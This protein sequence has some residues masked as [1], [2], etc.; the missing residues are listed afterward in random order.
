MRLSIYIVGL[1]AGLWLQQLTLKSSRLNRDG[2]TCQYRIHIPGQLLA[3][4]G[5]VMHGYSGNNNEC[6]NDYR[7][8]QLADVGGFVVA[9]P[10]GTRDQWNDRFSDVDYSFH[11]GI[12]TLWIDFIE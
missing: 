11:D 4:P 1:G 3:S 10:N 8:T 5:L 12:G 7:W 9:V 6:M 2:L